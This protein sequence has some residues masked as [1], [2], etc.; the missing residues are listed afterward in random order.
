MV[1]KLFQQLVTEF[2][3]WVPA[4]QPLLY[5]AL[6]KPVIESPYLVHSTVDLGLADSR[7]LQ[8]GLQLTGYRV[9]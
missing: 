8:I 7:Y 9:F 4:T 2:T 5:S 3:D 6:Q 1:V